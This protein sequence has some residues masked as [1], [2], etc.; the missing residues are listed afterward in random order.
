MS[1]KKSVLKNILIITSILIISLFYY[2][3][4]SL[5]N[6]LYKINGNIIIGMQGLIENYF[7]TNFFIFNSHFSIWNNIFVPVLKIPLTILLLFIYY[8]IKVFTY[9]NK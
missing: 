1:I 5:G 2:E 3:T 6:L 8:L 7:K 4:L 9:K